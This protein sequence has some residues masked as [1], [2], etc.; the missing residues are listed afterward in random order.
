MIESHGAS[1]PPTRI[2]D[3]MAH[4]FSQKNTALKPA[5]PGEAVN[6]PI[7]REEVV[8]AHEPREQIS[9][10]FRSLR[11]SI[12]ALNTD[13]AS[14]TLVMASALR[15]EGKTVATINLAAAMAELNASK[16]AIVVI[17]VDNNILD[18]EGDDIVLNTTYA[19]GSV[20]NL[21]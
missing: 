15:G 3:P 21:R 11:N 10:Q 18:V 9:E 8:I 4:P 19:A 20:V 7:K 12:H 16:L 17:K 2:P 13:G 5:E 14:H 6:L 1:R